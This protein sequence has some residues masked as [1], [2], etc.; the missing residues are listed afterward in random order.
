MLLH[1]A[2]SLL[3]AELSIPAPFA[4]VYARFAPTSD[5]NNHQLLDRARIQLLPHNTLLGS[6]LASVHIGHS[7]CI[8]VFVVT[9]IDGIHDATQRL[10]HLQL[11]GLAVAQPS[12]FTFDDLYPCSPACSLLPKPCPSC[13]SPKIGMPLP[14]KPLR[15][16]YSH[17][18]E[19][20]RIRFIDDIAQAASHSRPLRPVTRLKG[21]FLLGSPTID[22]EWCSSWHYRVQ[23]SLIIHPLLCPT[24]FLP[25]SYSLPVPPGTPITLLPHGTPAFFLAHYNGPTSALTKQFQDS[26]QGLGA[27]SWSSTSKTYVIAWINVENKQGED[28]GIV[29][30]YPTALCLSLTPSLIPP[31]PPLEHIPSLPTALQPSPHMSA[32]P[33]PSSISSASPQIPYPPPSALYSQ[34][35][36]VIPSSPSSDSVRAFRAL[37]LSKS[38][39]IHQIAAE[40]A[41]YVDAVARDREKERERL[42][43]ERESNNASTSP[44]FA[45]TAIISATGMQSPPTISSS[46]P[47]LTT[48][49]S[50]ASQ[51]PVAST[52]HPP[53][54]N[55]YPSPPQ[56]DATPHTGPT[57]PPTFLPPPS[58]LKPVS[59]PSEPPPA[60]VVPP[61]PQTAFD[62]F[63]TT[64]ASWAI[65][66]Q[67]YLG[68]NMNMDMDMDMD[69]EFDMNIGMDMNMSMPFNVNTS[70]DATF[71][72]TSRAGDTGSGSGLD[73]D[74][75]TDDDFSF[76]DRPSAPAACPPLPRSMPITT[77]TTLP[78]PTT[79]QTPSNFDTSPLFTT[80]ISS[81]TPHNALT[82][83]WVSSAT[84]TATPA[85]PDLLPPSPG[86]TPSSHSAPAT[87]TATV[88]LEPFISSNST[89]DPI[90]FADY[91]RLLDGKYA[92]GKFSLP[93]PTQ[94]LDDLA[95][96]KNAGR[97]G[98]RKDYIAATDPRIGVVRKLIGVK[99]KMAFEQR[100]KVAKSPISTDPPS[101][102]DDWSSP[103]STSTPSP[104]ADI[105]SDTASSV[106]SCSSS[107]TPSP[108]HSRPTTPPPAYLPA[109]PALLSTYFTHSSLLPLS[110]PLRR[111]SSPL[112]LPNPHSHPRIHSAASALTPVSPAATLG[113]SKSL[114]T[115]AGAV[116]TEV[117]ENSPWA[118]AWCA[119]TLV[120]SCAQGEVWLADA[121]AIS[122]LF[123]SVLGFEGSM[124]LGSLFCDRGMGENGNEKKTVGEKGTLKMLEAP[125]ITIGKGDAVIQVLPTALRFWEKLGLGPKGGAKNGTVFVLFED[126]GE[127]RMQQVDAWL[128]SVAASYEGRHLGTLTPGKN[129]ICPR[130][131]L[132]PLRFD[133]SFR[134]TLASLIASLPASQSSIFLIVT[135]MSILTLAS[136][137][138]RQIFSAVTKASRTYSEAQ[139]HFQ[140]VPEQLLHGTFTNPASDYSTSDVCC[141]IYNRILVPVDRI[142]SRSLSEHG[143]RVRKY[144]Q[145][146]A[147]TLARPIYSKATFVRAAH[148]S[149]DVLDRDTFLHVGYQ[150]GE[151]HDLGVWLVQTPVDGDL[152]SEDVSNEVFLVQKV[153]EFAIEFAK[154]A[155]VEWRIV[156]SKLGAIG[157]NELDTW[158]NWI[159]NNSRALRVSSFTVLSVEPDAPWTFIS[160]RP[161]TPVTKSPPTKVHNLSRTSSSAKVQPRNIFTDITMTVFATSP[162]NSIPQSYPPSLAN[163][164]VFLSHVPED[165]GQSATSGFE[166]SPPPSLPH[167]LPLLP[168]S[169]T[170]LICI[171]ATPSPTSISM[172]HLHLLHNVRSPGSI[173]SAQDMSSLHTA[174]THNFHELAVLARARW[175]LHVNPVLPLHLAAV[176]AMRI[177][178]GRDQYGIDI[179]DST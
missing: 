107:P 78:T 144:F 42:K 99:R 106:S 67:P 40:V 89:F 132:L 19:A 3:A 164:G 145:A 112:P 125:M 11:D 155:N 103:T 28:K 169:S 120:G 27:G 46:A 113:Q 58:T 166:E 165:V 168:R 94:G 163:L 124:T 43:R 153:W 137:T 108:P 71:G 97:I 56:A 88:H 174:I 51:Q 77:T 143:V 45:R 8:Y 22:N 13:L 178:L 20:I 157:E 116:A 160:T 105:D 142:M 104:D 173:S 123:G 177:A 114:E 151:A 12:Y 36:P 133:S 61:P 82:S 9:G 59:Q 6:L 161:K 175:R 66:P 26:L 171:P 118:E 100:A 117:V 64:D 33:P 158:T 37:T 90:P 170:T 85:V 91:H 10:A 138:L 172:L 152:E 147:F 159:D 110:T 16:I 87:P 74:D 141:S 111:P 53:P 2:D 83:P 115:A 38:K 52:S 121:R 15:E 80:E 162:Y 30:I 69:M 135:P 129:P 128:G 35:Q 54:P 65:Q 84:H 79:A 57:S 86:P 41:G 39:D 72:G 149:L 75:I 4:V 81:V 5:S 24:N 68:L 140:F 63:N 98:W 73:F 62:P 23:S 60:P 17:F 101:W 93:S 109:G 130:D 134:K 136:P 95:K 167:P 1:Q 150:R 148:A 154:K 7:S 32:Q 122:Q 179:A 70:R 18:L 34:P 49:L 126:D 127:Q 139:I 29:L 47:L 131:G 119:S 96:A 25:L 44:K 146:P 31:R 55:F 48:P 156:F 176:E 102:V 92:V 50:L 76:F 14:R 21:G